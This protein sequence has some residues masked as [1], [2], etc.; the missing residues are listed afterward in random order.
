M[1]NT[2]P[3]IEDLVRLIRVNRERAEFYKELAATSRNAQIQCTFH[4]CAYE[5][6]KFDESL[7][8]W[9]IAYGTTQ[10]LHSVA[11]NMFQKLSRKLR[12]KLYLKTSNLLNCCAYVEGLTQQEYKEVLEHDSLTFAALKDVKAQQEALREN[13]QLVT[14]SMIYPFQVRNSSVKASA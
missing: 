9:L 8:K 7:S 1:K 13:F 2:S 11:E 4:Q 14:D 6:I 10:A 5:S 12:L 3:V